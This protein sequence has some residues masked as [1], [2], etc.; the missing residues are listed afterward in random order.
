MKRG[1]TVRMPIPA[2]F[3]SMSMPPSRD[4]AWSTARATEDSSRTSRP[5]P[6]APGSSAATA[7]ART[8]DRP[9]SA[10]LAPAA[11]R[12]EAIARPRPLVP[13]VTSTFSV[14]APMTARL[15]L[16]ACPKSSGRRYRGLP[17]AGKRTGIEFWEAAP[18]RVRIWSPW[19]SVRRVPR[20]SAPQLAFVQERYPRGS[21]LD[22]YTPVSEAPAA[23]QR[24]RRLARVRSAREP[25]GSDREPR[26][27]GD[28]LP[29][30]R[31][32]LRPSRVGAMSHASNRTRPGS[33]PRVGRLFRAR[34]CRHTY[35]APAASGGQPLGLTGRR[36]SS[37]PLELGAR[38]R[39][40]SAS[41]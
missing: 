11:A 12:A 27:D 19:T 41:T 31:P 35:S 5:R 16:I 18:L 36:P 38:W 21:R 10:T 30:V 17:E 22:C 4:H 24:Q 25:R 23:H 7:R 26:A 28:G 29:A 6:T 20:H 9:V 8:A 14:E 40:R 39:F 34:G 37:D 3:T 1:L 33:G 13:P 15:R 32:E 2:L